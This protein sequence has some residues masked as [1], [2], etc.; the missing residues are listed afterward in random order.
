VETALIRDKR[1]E[2]EQ[3]IVWARP[4]G[5]AIIVILL[6]ISVPTLW[7]RQGQQVS[8]P[9]EIAG[10]ALVQVAFLVWIWRMPPVGRVVSVSSSGL[11]IEVRSR[12]LDIAPTDVTSAKA[13]YV[14]WGSAEDGSPRMK[15]VFKCVLKLRPG[16]PYRKVILFDDRQHTIASTLSA[17]GVPVAAEYDRGDDDEDISVP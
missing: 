9:L 1:V 13:S 5:S 11:T 2:L 15:S 10:I 4:I 17:S 12:R 14:Q 7:A 3:S 6:I 8:G 16:L